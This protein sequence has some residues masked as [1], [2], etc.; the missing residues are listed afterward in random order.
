MAGSVIL[1]C[2]FWQ[3]ET[4]DGLMKTSFIA[5]EVQPETTFFPVALI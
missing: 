3:Q 4:K 2:G 5:E 1:L